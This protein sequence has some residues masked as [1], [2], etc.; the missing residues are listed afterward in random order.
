M[1]GDNYRAACP[2]IL[3]QT[4]KIKSQHRYVV[5]L[6]ALDTRMFSRAVFSFD[7]RGF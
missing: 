2:E 7:L 3:G 5:N 1:G 4:K 6:A